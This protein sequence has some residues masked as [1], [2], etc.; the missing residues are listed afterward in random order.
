MSLPQLPR[1][2]RKV[3]TFSETKPRQPIA[4][5]PDLLHLPRL[6]GCHDSY[7]CCVY[8]IHEA[9]N[10]TASLTRFESGSRG[11]CRGAQSSG[12]FTVSSG[13]CLWMTAVCHLRPTCGR[14]DH[15]LA[16]VGARA[17]VQWV[18]FSVLIDFCDIIFQPKWW[19]ANDANILSTCHV[20]R[21]YHVIRIDPKPE[22]QIYFCFCI[23]FVCL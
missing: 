13:I 15:L 6:R 3:G 4:C 9:N 14:S 17:W 5:S 21:V 10:C 2:E 16:Q 19:N 23:D 22:Q 11:S 8:T 1:P 7:T 12:N 18:S 20:I